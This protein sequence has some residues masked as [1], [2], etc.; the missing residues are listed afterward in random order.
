MELNEN[1]QIYLAASRTSNNGTSGVFTV[2]IRNAKVVEE[3]ESYY[4]YDAAAV[5]GAWWASQKAIDFGSEYANKEVYVTLTLCGNADPNKTASMGLWGY[6]TASDIGSLNDI[7]REQLSTYQNWSKVTFKCQLD[8]NG[9]WLISPGIKES[10]YENFTIFVKDVEVYEYYS[11]STGWQSSDQFFTLD[12]S[13][14]ETV[15]AYEMIDLQLDVRGVISE[16]GD[17]P[18]GFYYDKTTSG[19]DSTYGNAALCNIDT[20]IRSGE[21]QTV[22]ITVKLD[23][24]KKVRL[25]ASRT[26]NSG[27]ASTF[28]LFIRNIVKK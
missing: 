13:N 19:A 20:A 7:S 15:S 28:E 5:G 21:W 10:K 18:L 25:A 17:S 16:A 8:A 24:D 23:A 1:G 22:T 9:K 12:F 11:K 14:D 26:S 3:I 27:T 6:N 2:K 4:T